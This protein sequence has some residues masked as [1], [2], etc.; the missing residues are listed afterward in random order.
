MQHLV[1]TAI[2]VCSLR[3]AVGSHQIVIGVDTSSTR[4]A[5]CRLQKAVIGLLG[6]VGLVQTLQ[7][8]STH[9][10]DSSLIFV[11]ISLSGIGFLTIFVQQH[12][13]TVY[14]IDGLGIA[15]RVDI[16]H[17]GIYG[18]DDCLLESTTGGV[19]LPAVGIV[20]T[21]F[22]ETF[23]GF[24]ITSQ[25]Q[26]A[27][28]DI[29]QQNGIVDIR[30][31]TRLLHSGNG[32]NG[33]LQRALEVALDQQQLRKAACRLVIAQL[34][35][36]A[37]YFTLQH[38]S[39]AYLCHAVHILMIVVYA[40]PAVGIH[41]RDVARHLK[42]VGQRLQT[43]IVHHGTSG[44]YHAVSMIAFQLGLLALSARFKQHHRADKGYD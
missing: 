9:N 43:V 15:T 5:I 29:V 16:G 38:L 17:T 8:H 41:L 40:T 11:E 32:R 35:L 20:L 34:V 22:Q 33:N 26:L 37:L 23:V 4:L 30:T 7:G 19:C 42:T 14:P 6:L 1:Q 39:I 31:H 12:L 21:G 18:A 36:V 3:I 13:C 44:K 24:G 25:V 2:V 27:T 28:A 10:L